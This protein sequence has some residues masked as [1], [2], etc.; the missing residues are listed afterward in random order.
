MP[1]KLTIS[2][3]K[4]VATTI[5]LSREGLTPPI[6]LAGSF[7]NWEASIEMEYDILQDSYQASHVFHKTIDLEPGI[8]QYKFQL[9]HGDWWIA[10]DKAPK[11]RLPAWFKNLT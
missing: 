10:D 3:L 1:S 2:I 5:H 9:G 7:T 11:C 4:M 8:Y 6:F